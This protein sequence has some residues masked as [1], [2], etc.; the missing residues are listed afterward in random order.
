MIP[1]AEDC[2]EPGKA[3]KT[4]GQAHLKSIPARSLP[5]SPIGSNRLSVKLLV[6]RSPGA[7][8]GL[9]GQDEQKFE[10]A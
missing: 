4:F 1:T 6:L 7:A 2:C 10:R 3:S 8:L 9:A 5:R